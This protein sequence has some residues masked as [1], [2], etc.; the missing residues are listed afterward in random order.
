MTG[1]LFLNGVDLYGRSSDGLTNYARLSMTNTETSLI[2]QVNR[3]VVLN[4][5]GAAILTAA[6]TLVTSTMPVALP[7]DPASALH[8]ATKQYVDGKAGLTQ[9]AADALYV[10]VGGDIMTGPLNLHGTTIV[11]KDAPGTTT[12]GTI[13]G[14]AQGV[15]IDDLEV[16]S[17]FVCQGYA[18]FNSGLGTSETISISSDDLMF[19]LAGGVEYGVY[20]YSSGNPQGRI[21]HNATRMDVKG[22][23]PGG[24]MGV[25]VRNAANTLDLGLTLSE[26]TVTAGVPITLPGAP[27]SSLHAATKQYVD[28]NA[29]GGGGAA[30]WTGTQAEFDALATLDPATFYYVMP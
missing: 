15:S 6:A 27:T 12:R 8:A 30:T 4:V 17:D 25:T 10:N 24:V 21:V 5:G 23:K 14:S 13:S 9:V 16:T 1:T 2:G 20:W 26:T 7:A 22:D 29:G 28:D 19:T 3:P 11:V 18:D